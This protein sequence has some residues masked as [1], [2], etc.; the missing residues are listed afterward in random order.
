MSLLVFPLNIQATAGWPVKKTPRYNTI[1]QFPAS[2]RSVIRIPTMLFPLWDF[3]FDITYI[4]GDPTGVDT[5]WQQ[6]V[7]FYM[8]AQGAANDWLFLD[9]YDSLVGSYTITGSVVSGVF[10]NQEVVTQ[11]STGASATLLF[12]VSGAN[13]MDIGPYTGTPDSNTSHHWVG[14]S[15][16]AQYSPTDTPVLL[17]SQGIATADNVTT[18]FTM[19]RSLIVGGAQDLIQNFVNPPSIYVNGSLTNSSTYTINQYGT[20]TFNTAPVTGT[21]AW[22]GSFYFRCSFKQDSWD[23]LEEDYYQIWKMDGLKF[24]SVLL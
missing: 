17:T 16:G 2:G 13:N 21:I 12:A 20:L 19:Y 5:T 7:N 1:T 9:P 24:S 14:Q 18:E 11:Q 3:V 22:T 8:A 23:S 4:Q 6:L 10:V 15:S